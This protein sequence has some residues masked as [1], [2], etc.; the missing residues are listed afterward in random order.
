[1]AKFNLTDECFNRSQETVA[2]TPREQMQAC[3]AISC[4][5]AGMMCGVADIVDLLTDHCSGP[6]V[7]RGKSDGERFGAGE[8]VLT[9]EGA[10]GE[11]VA[12]ETLY[13]GILSLS[14]GAANMAAI[15]EAAGDGVRIIDL[16][17]RHYP[18]EL[19]S[20]LA[21]AAAVGG[22]QGTTTRSGHTAVIERFGVGGELIRIG[23]RQAV[24]FNLYGGVPHALSAVYE[25]STVE[26]ADAYRT[27]CPEA[28]LVIRLDFEG[29][30]RETCSEAVRRF[31]SALDI[32]RLE[33]AD[34][35]I[36][37]GGHEQAPRALEMRILSQAKDRQAAAAGLER[38]GFGPGV[39]V[40]EVYAIRDLLDSLGARSTRIMASGGF[41][42]EKVRAFR[43]CNAP[44]DFIGT[45]RW[46]EFADFTGDIFRVVED[47]QWVRR[48]RAGR[49]D[50]V[51]EPENL[52]VV[53]Q[54]E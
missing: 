42:V 27:V 24:A 14:A 47:G 32:V 23:E 40:E 9:L 11:L 44:V 37:E 54:K 13:L 3:Y 2:G 52:P 41:D 31:G 20:P 38:Y 35:R 1:M 10:F 30:E 6:L 25:G 18:P 51:I 53:F 19:V 22:A 8:V 39:T 36:H 48:C 34:N 45:S 16:S 49:D 21:I 29:R 43:A 28:S 17:A 5:Q 7:L 46:V 12:L 4:R 15:V 50:E 26:S 33:T